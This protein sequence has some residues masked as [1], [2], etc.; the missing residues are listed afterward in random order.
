MDFLVDGTLVKSLPVDRLAAGEENEL[1][2]RWPVTGVHTIQ[3]IADSQGP[4]VKVITGQPG[5]GNSER[6]DLPGPDHNGCYLVA[7]NFK[8][9]G[10]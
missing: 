8:Y 5:G 10:A 9:A 3:V 1:R 7:V 2:V 4:Y 6:T